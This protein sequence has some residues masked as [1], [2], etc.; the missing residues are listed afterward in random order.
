MALAKDS[1]GNNYAEVDMGNGEQ[2]RVTYIKES[3]AGKGGVRI[4]IRDGDGHLRQGPEFPAQISRDVVA[5]INDLIS[6]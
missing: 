4:Q 5:A 3:W 1:R 6:I 2:V